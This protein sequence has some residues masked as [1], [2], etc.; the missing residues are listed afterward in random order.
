VFFSLLLGAKIPS[1]IRQKRKLIPQEEKEVE[2]TLHR[3]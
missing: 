2:E 1:F 3:E